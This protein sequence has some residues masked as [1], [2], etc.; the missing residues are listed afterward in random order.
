MSVGVW[1]RHFA[2][3]DSNC[4]FVYLVVLLAVAVHEVLHLSVGEGQHA[5]DVLG[6]PILGGLQLVTVHSLSVAAERHLVSTLSS[7]NRVY[8]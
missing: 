2:Y 4:L 5:A 8:V 7:N 3:Y 1:W 6:H